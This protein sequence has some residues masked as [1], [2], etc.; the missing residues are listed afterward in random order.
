MVQQ[1][2][3]CAAALQAGVEAWGVELRV[4]GVHQ[5]RQQAVLAQ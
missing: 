5:P 1:A 2:A 4:V 3:G